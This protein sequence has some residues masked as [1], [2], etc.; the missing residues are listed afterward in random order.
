MA[1]FQCRSCGF[2]GH[3]TWTGELICPE[4]GTTEGVRVAGGMEEMS[5]LE[6]LEAILEDLPEDY[7]VKDE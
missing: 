4:C 3:G 6:I 5:N 1:R 2:D 7:P